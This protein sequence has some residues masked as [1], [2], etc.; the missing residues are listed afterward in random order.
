[1]TY[2]EKFD[3]L[4]KELQDKNKRFFKA[5]KE[6]TAINGFIDMSVL[7]NYR[8]AKKNLK[9]AL[10]NFYSFLAHVKKIG[11]KPDDLYASLY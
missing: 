3:L 7:R 11:A 6:I 9:I 2:Q 5:D 10:N 8:T 4:W 1:M